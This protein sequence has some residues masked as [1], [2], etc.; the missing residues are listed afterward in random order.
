MQKLVW[1]SLKKKPTDHRSDPKIG[2]H[3]HTLGSG[4]Y[5]YVSIHMYKGMYIRFL[6]L[7]KVGNSTPKLSKCLM[8]NRKIAI[9]TIWN[10]STNLWFEIAALFFL[11]WA[12]RAQLKSRWFEPLRF[13]GARGCDLKS[14]AICVS[15]SP[16]TLGIQWPHYGQTTHGHPDPH[17]HL[18]CVEHCDWIKVVKVSFV[19]ISWPRFPVEAICDCKSNPTRVW[20][21]CLFLFYGNVNVGVNS[22]PFS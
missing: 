22:V 15:S 1:Q 21:V 3:I 19:T 8:P 13:Q 18:P 12:Q 17:G 9:V 14:L 10:R 2:T 6:D 4:G 11:T 5:A 7:R 20:H 16:L